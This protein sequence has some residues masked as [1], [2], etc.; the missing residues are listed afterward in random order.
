MV[1]VPVVM[2]AVGRVFVG[3]G[4]RDRHE[5]EGGGEKLQF[6]LRSPDDPPNL[7]DFARSGSIYP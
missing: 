2:P 4:R 1:V 3:H 7:Y 6:H 5:G